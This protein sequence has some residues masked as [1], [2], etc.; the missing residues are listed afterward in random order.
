MPSW[1]ATRSQLLHACATTRLVFS[2]L[3]IELGP[4]LCRDAIVPASA[5]DQFL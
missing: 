3:P 5:G 2:Y 4:L 1:S